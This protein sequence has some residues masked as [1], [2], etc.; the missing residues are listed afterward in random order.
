MKFWRHPQALRCVRLG[1]HL[2][3]IGWVSGVRPVS[4]AD[5]L[6]PPLAGIKPDHP[7][8]LLRPAATPW[9]ISLTQ[10]QAL[11]RDVEFNAMLDQLKKQNDTA[12][13]AMVWV[14]TH[15]PAAAEKA[16]RRMR[17]YR[18]PGRVD[19]FHIYGR[20]TEFGLAYDWLYHC[21]SFTP[22]IKSEVRANVAPLAREALR[23][24]NDHM[25]HNYIWMSAGGLALWGLAT[26]GEDE[27][28]NAVFEQMR[29]RFND[30]LFPAMRYLDGLPSEPMGYWSL[31]CFT[32]AVWTVLASQ[33]AFETDLV[34]AIRRRQN[35]WLDRH[36][37]NV[38]HSTLPDMRF[39]PW[40]DLQGGPNGSVTFEM[41]GVMDAATWALHSA[42]G[43]QFGQWL[44][45]RRGLARFYGETAVYN[46]LYTRQLA[47]AVTNP[48]AWPPPSFLAGNRQ[49]GH[50]IAR[51]SWDDGATV[52]AFA[53]TDHFGDHHHFDQGS[54]IIYRRGLL[55]V[56]PPVYRQVRGPQQRTEN[57]NTLLIG[58]QPQRP[59][60]GQWFV[61]VEDF[62]KN[63]Q[64]GRKL[65]TGD[66]LFW[67]EAGPWA[68]VSGQFAQAYDCPELQSCVRQLLFLR[69]D[70]IVVVDRLRAA[71]GQR[72]PEVQWL[73]QLP[74]QP[75]D[76]AGAI[77][78][79][80][81]KSWIRLRPLLPTGAAS[82]IVPT[83]VNTQRVTL[84]YASQ[85]A[86]TLIHLL[87]VGDGDSP[88]AAA[89]VEVVEKQ[90]G[91]EITL[92]GETFLF[93][94]NAQATVGA[95]AAP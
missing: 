52:V 86:L 34:S 80:N 61:T 18:Y 94:T 26:A 42:Q 64:A 83:P 87:E 2:A 20:L 60:R 1:L 63:L 50:F 93:A 28:A 89:P 59:V 17:A 78:S 56:D 76:E 5:E 85:P 53:C 37:E 6:I 27:A 11:E 22:D 4:G 13:Q 16:I 69:P 32:P 49:S 19:T 54:F 46:L 8:V 38:I 84:T 68:A 91:T 47:T 70:K 77:T 71:P 92:A 88:G 57:H 7:R 81:G 39:M 33:S 41:A 95:R 12:S 25:F 67:R 44:A 79:S 51:S 72:V 65:E 48:P 21:P 62:Q 40:G 74:G 75:R 55:A 15:D 14:L 30:G 45:A 35:G 66:L 73:L 24:A 29:R 36:F 9:A 58:G 10:L 90:A 3:F 82:S 43:R 31:Y 23:V